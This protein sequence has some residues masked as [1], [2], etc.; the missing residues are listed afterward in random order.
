M[1]KLFALLV[2]ALLSTPALAETV[3]VNKT[4]H[5][6]GSQA[7]VSVDFQVYEVSKRRDTLLLS[8]TLSSAETNSETPLSFTREKAYVALIQDDGSTRE[9]YP[10][11]FKEGMTAV[12]KRRSGSPAILQ[13]DAFDV[14]R[15]ANARQQDEQGLVEKTGFSTSWFLEKGR[16]EYAF[17]ANGKKYRTVLTVN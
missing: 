8:G 7:L 1:K 10:D 15:V 6:D 17:K 12:L 5:D 16:Q 13:L 3:M 11:T 9:F 4:P 2:L 14:K